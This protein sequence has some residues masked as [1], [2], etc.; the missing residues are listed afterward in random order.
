MSYNVAVTCVGCVIVISDPKKAVGTHVFDVTLTA[1]LY[2]LP[3]TK[4]GTVNDPEPVTLVVI[5]LP[6]VL[7]VRLI[8]LYVYALVLLFKPLFAAI[9][10]TNE[11]VPPLHVAL[12]TA[13]AVK[14]IP[15]IAELLTVAGLEIQGDALLSLKYISVVRLPVNVE[16]VTLTVVDVVDI[17]DDHAPLVPPT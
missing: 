5:V 10:T 12:V 17:A 3:A 1:T 6:V 11:P 15:R 16:P 7:S 13:P 8:N 4:E 14:V 2:V 9:L